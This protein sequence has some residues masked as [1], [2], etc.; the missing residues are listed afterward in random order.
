MADN[1]KTAKTPKVIPRRLCYADAALKIYSYPT[2]ILIIC[3]EYCGFVMKFSG[4][5]SKDS[6]DSEDFCEYISSGSFSLS[7]FPSK[8]I[9]TPHKK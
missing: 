6:K 3:I 5:S 1:T 7:N 8:K 4:S 9:S 2:M